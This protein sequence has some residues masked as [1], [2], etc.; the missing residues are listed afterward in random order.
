M[1]VDVRPLLRL[2]L[3]LGALA[4]GGQRA[5][6]EPPA[7][8][9]AGPVERAAVDRAI[10]AG[11]RWLL[12]EQRPD[13]AFG[14]SGEDALGETALSALALQ[15]AGVRE[16]GSSAGDRAL[17]RT[18][19]WID[20]QG[21]GRA[22]ARDRDPGTYTT[23]LLLLVLRERGREADRPRMQRLADLLVRTQAQ[24]GQWGYAGEPGDTGRGG[25][26]VGDNSNTQ[27]ALLAL[28]AA[29]GEGLAVERA[30][31]DRALGWWLG[32]QAEDGGF[33]YASGGSRAS[34]AT[35]SM[36]AAGLACLAV[37]EA[38]RGEVVA[39]GAGAAAALR[40][41]QERAAELLARTYSVSRNFGPAPG[42]VGQ[43][44]K[45][46][47]RGW[48]HYYLWTLERALVLAGH[49]RLVP[50]GAGPGAGHDWFPDGTRH[51]LGTQREDGSWVAEAPLYATCFAL[52][53]LT[54]AADPA[55]AFT[56]PA[57]STGP[58]TP[59]PR[60]A[61]PAPDAPSGTPA[62]GPDEPP[63]PRAVPPPA[64]DELARR[65]LRAGP[66]SLALL[67]RALDDEDAGVRRRALEALTLLLGAERVE[68][69]DRHP[70]A[71]GRLL[72]WVRRHARLL[73]AREGRFVLEG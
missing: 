25:P 6:G 53:F 41:A 46:A 34:A 17:T 38:C 55:R 50:P 51:L 11:V 12:A 5:R 44:Q 36:T 19:A 4:L 61:P 71:R 27:F 42:G 2:G 18:L 64:P 35:G 43:R 73:V 16:G 24:N 48:P 57:R 45:N 23:A 39:G 26:E 54:R 7:P 72:L 66:G 33:G 20:R 22:G 3:V 67:V 70:L 10:E 59:G 9:P 49:E 32:A 1:R 68:G 65:A 13:G 63:D 29:V 31:L 58:V 47:G 62:A 52:L 21:P 56:P 37:L 14:G 69:A 8:A 28:G 30:C 60:A 40:R 15:H